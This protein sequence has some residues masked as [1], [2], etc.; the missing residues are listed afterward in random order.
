MIPL[1]LALLLLL[2]PAT[3]GGSTKFG[4]TW[5]KSHLLAHQPTKEHEDYDM[6]VS[7]HARAA[8]RHS[9]LRPVGMR[10]SDDRMQMPA[11]DASQTEAM[12]NDETPQ[13]H[14]R[15][16]PIPKRKRMTRGLED[17]TLAS[18]T[19]NI[20]PESNGSGMDGTYNQYN[21]TYI[22]VPMATDE[23]DSPATI[24][25][26]LVV[27]VMGGIALMLLG[28]CFGRAC[29]EQPHHRTTTVA[30]GGDVLVASADDHTMARTMAHRR[31][32]AATPV[33][34]PPESSSSSSDEDDHSNGSGYPLRP[35][36]IEPSELTSPTMVSTRVPPQTSHLSF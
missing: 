31:K 2:S 6:M 7:M 1:L 36:I 26:P 29:G 9:Q 12:S 13:F 17:E 28:C 16:S 18:D 19:H 4:S 22:P 27:G 24:S 8:D 34:T 30:V 33:A 11:D 15:S 35:H 25:L 3:V 14:T 21:N 5:D 23:S 20:A 10:H 32:T